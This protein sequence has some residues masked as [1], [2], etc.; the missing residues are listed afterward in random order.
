M[1]HIEDKEDNQWQQD[2]QKDDDALLSHGVR[3]FGNLSLLLPSFVD[4]G[5][6]GSIVLPLIT[7]DRVN[8]I[9]DTLGGEKGH[10]LTAW[11]LIGGKERHQIGLQVVHRFGHLP[12]CG[13]GVKFGHHVC[14]V[15]P[16]SGILQIF[17]I[18]EE[19]DAGFGMI[20]FQ[21]LLIDTLCLATLSCPDEHDGL[22]GVETAL[23]FVGNTFRTVGWSD[24]SFDSFL[25]SG[26]PFLCLF[27][28]LGA[29]VCIH[30]VIWYSS[31]RED[32]LIFLGLCGQIFQG[33]VGLGEV[34]LRLGD[35]A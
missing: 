35:A 11:F 3:L 7:V 4:D 12:G 32:V 9:N 16:S 13:E 19:S 8:G 18:V 26:D 30:N 2:N 10:L 33:V 23:I 17:C 14:H 25:G 24:H 1:E 22:M 5:Q 20:G 27:V 21:E 31:P 34:L 6:L 15:L 28:S 29:G